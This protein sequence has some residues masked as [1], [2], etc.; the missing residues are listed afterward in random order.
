MNKS[1]ILLLQQR[2]AL[3]EGKSQSGDGSAVGAEASGGIGA[4]VAPKSAGGAS[5]KRTRSVSA[6]DIEPSKKRSLA[7]VSKEPSLADAGS[8]VQVVD[9]LS[10]GNA[11]AS[12]E[13]KDPLDD[14]PLSVRFGGDPQ[15]EGTERYTLVRFKTGQGWLSSGEGAE[16]PI[17][18]LNAFK[19]SPDRKMLEKTADDEA[20]GRAKEAFGVVCL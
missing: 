9:L 12:P 17:E 3:R 20:I 5:S 2:K 14:L 6:E 16:T 13:A 8:N 7:V 19:L 11:V 1:R 10:E 4:P 15:A 18:A